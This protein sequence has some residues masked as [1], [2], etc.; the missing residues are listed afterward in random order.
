MCLI[1]IK[2]T[3]DNRI[4][5]KK[6]TIDIWSSLFESN[7]KRSF[8]VFRIQPIDSSKFKSKPNLK[9]T[10]TYQKPVT[11][12]KIKQTPIRKHSQKKNKSPI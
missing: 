11:K 3:R 9:N 5:E 2:K 10:D 7:D 4:D 8:V 1:F 12:K 6:K